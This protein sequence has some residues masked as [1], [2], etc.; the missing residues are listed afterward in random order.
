VTTA[1]IANYNPLPAIGYNYYI[2][3]TPSLTS[4]SILYRLIINNDQSWTSMDLSYLA[5]SRPDVTVGNFE[6]PANTWVPSTSNIYNVYANI[7][8]I[9]PPN[10]YYVAVFISGFST[11][12]T[13]FDLTINNKAYDATNKN[14]AISFYCVSNPIILSITFSYIIYPFAHPTLDFTYSLIPL[15]NGGSYQFTGPV[16]F[17]RN[18][19]VTYN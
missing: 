12:S 15:R 7:S 19:V 5:C 17:Q 18:K 4:N 3:A 11:I 6:A 14:L 2:V 13:G 10:S 9:L 8:R 16:N 1:T